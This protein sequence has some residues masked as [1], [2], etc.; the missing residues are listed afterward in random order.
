MYLFVLL[1]SFLHFTH[2][3]I[4]LFITV[5]VEIMFSVLF[6]Y[7][8]FFSFR[9]VSF[10]SSYQ[11]QD[12]HLFASV[13]CLISGINK[14]YTPKIAKYEGLSSL[15]VRS[16]PPVN[17]LSFAAL[18]PFVIKLTNSPSSNIEHVVDPQHPL[19]VQAQ[20]DGVIVW[21]KSLE[22]GVEVGCCVGDREK[23]NLNSIK[24]KSMYN[25]GL[26]S[27]TS[28]LFQTLPLSHVRRQSDNT[29]STFTHNKSTI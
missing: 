24:N 5:T 17:R 2:C 28:V 22:A 25:A 3:I 20:T 10:S 14:E 4:L 7:L 6:I 1:K 29:G 19:E 15:L 16:C 18:D 9:F 8:F 21:H 11:L 12:V 27:H 26:C 13:S 23:T